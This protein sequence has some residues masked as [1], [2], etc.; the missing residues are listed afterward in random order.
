MPVSYGL[1]KVRLSHYFLPVSAPTRLMQISI[2]APGRMAY[3]KHYLLNRSRSRPITRHIR[4]TACHQEDEAFSF[5]RLHA[6]QCL[7]KG[8]VKS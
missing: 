1:F 5:G 8:I 6:L 2:I 3:I 4:T 7:S